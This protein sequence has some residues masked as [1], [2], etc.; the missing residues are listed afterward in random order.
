MSEPETSVGGIDPA[1]PLAGLRVVALEQAVAA[2]AKQMR[3]WMLMKLP[4]KATLETST[5]MAFSPFT[6][7]LTRRACSGRT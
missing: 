6:F 7:W 2:R 1:G 4:S 5:A 3:A